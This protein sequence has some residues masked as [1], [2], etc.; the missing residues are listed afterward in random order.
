V[1]AI[2]A[3]FHGL[4]MNRFGEARPPAA[5]VKFVEGSEKGLARN[6]VDIKP[7]LVVI[8]I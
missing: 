4:R 7:R 1:A 3:F 6:H 8:P 5:A 2:V